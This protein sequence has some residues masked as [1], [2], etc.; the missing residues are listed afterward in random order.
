[1]RIPTASRALRLLVRKPAKITEL[2]SA[3][4][5]PN[6]RNPD[7]EFQDSVDQADVRLRL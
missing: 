7:L 4:V 5:H 1:M 6:S 2:T 3:G